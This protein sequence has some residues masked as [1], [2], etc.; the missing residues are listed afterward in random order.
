MDVS[1]TAD[2]TF[3]VSADADTAFALLS[4]VPDSVAHFP[5]L[6]AFVADGADTWRWELAKLGHGPLTLQTVYTCRYASDADTRTVRWVAV[7]APKD[8]ARV[9]GSWT[10]TPSGSGS[11]LRLVNTLTITVPVP[12]LMRRAGEALVSRE[13]E[14]LILGYIGNLKQTLDGGDG[15]VR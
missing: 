15:R 4:D 6:D 13:N 14:R 8:N 5:G 10:L 12:R 3:T 9:E 2:H 1:A 11:R 7:S